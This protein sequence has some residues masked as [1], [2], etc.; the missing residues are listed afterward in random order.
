MDFNFDAT[1]EQIN[2]MSA[3]EHM[4]R[5]AHGGGTMG[6]AYIGGTSAPYWIDPYG[7]PYD[8]SMC[9]DRT[10]IVKNLLV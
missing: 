4:W 6:K 5:N 10:K 9:H 1:A 7:R 8:L 2:R 3:L